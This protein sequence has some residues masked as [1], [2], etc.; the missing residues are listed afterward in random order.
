MKL[1][2]GF[3]MRNLFFT[4]SL[5]AVCSAS[6]AQWKIGPKAGFGTITQSAEII[7]VVPNSDHGMYDLKFLGGSTVKYAGLTL[8]RDLGPFFLQLDALGTQYEL[9]YLLDEYKKMNESSPVY[10]EQYSLIE[11][12]FAAGVKLKN[13]KIGLGPVFDFNMDKDS[14]LGEMYDYQNT[15]N[16][17]DAGFQALIGYNLGILHFDV[18]YV[19]KFSGITDSFDFGNDIMKYNGSAN[20]LSLTV[21][22]V[23]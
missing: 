18:K 15:T 7:H 9:E 5:L 11:G 17:I 6:Q 14:Q 3:K 20:R 23:L 12:S 19:N 1:K 16:K 22:I 21:G 4:I 13:F 10:S 8:Y 2:F